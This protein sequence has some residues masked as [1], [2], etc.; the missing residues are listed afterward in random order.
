MAAT[1]ASATLGISQTKVPWWAILIQGIALIILGFL[2][3]TAPAATLVSLVFF[4]GIYWLIGGIMD[5]VGI[6]IN[7]T[8]WG[9]KL[10]SGLI[11]ILAG[12]LIMNHPL[13]TRGPAVGLTK[14]AKVR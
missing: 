12:V 10:F 14:S 4:L 6:F 9:W 3:L 1:T 11:G 8:A 2:F 5:I 7:K 13:W